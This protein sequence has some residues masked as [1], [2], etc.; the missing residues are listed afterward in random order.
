MNIRIKKGA[1]LSLAGALPQKPAEAR[2]DALLVA[3][4]PD[5]FPGFEPKPEVKAGDAVMQGQPLLR[6]KS[7]EAVKIVS[8][9]AGTVKEVVRGPRRKIE[10]VIIEVKP[11]G[12][13]AKLSPGS[14]Q[15]I[16]LL[17]LSGMLARMRQ[18]PY[19]IVPDPAVKPRDIFVTGIDSA[20]LARP[21]AQAVAGAKAE[22]EAGAALLGKVTD[23]KVYLSVGDDWQA[24]DVKGA[25][26]VHISGPHPVG[27]AGVQAANI[28]PVNKGEVVWT[29]S[30]ITLAKIGRVALT[31]TID[32]TTEVALVGSE[33]ETPCLLKTTEGAALAPLLTGRLKNDGADK[34]II[35]G[36]VLTGTAESADAFLR[37]PYTQITVIP[38][39]SHADEFMGWASLSP[40]KMSQSRAF[41]GWLL[42]KKYAPDARLNGGRRAM[43]MSGEYDKYMPMDILPEYLLKAIMARDIEAME[44][45]G[46]YEVAPEDFALAEYAD[47]SKL[48]L[49]RIVREGLD[50]LRHELS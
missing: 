34:R 8:P 35:S 40:S 47:T 24:G 20:P 33:V 41:L 15:P 46:I 5:D 37:F 43:I 36:N 14:M 50:Y 13:A 26:M 38:E 25:E 42:P 22:L 3:V 7:A 48:P 18:R 32:T 10:R 31:G 9:A 23:G 2:V 11:A 29:L 30:A 39:G 44:K 45:L 17:C 49:Q 27:L 28:A 6:S 4:T 1:N 21:M 19:D 12:E 16:E